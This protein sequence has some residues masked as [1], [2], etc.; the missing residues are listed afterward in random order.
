MST[1]FLTSFSEQEFRE[2]LRSTIKE[3]LSQELSKLS[4]SLPDTLG[5]EDAAAFLK[6]KIATIYEKTSK[7]LIPHF[8]KG[9]KLYFY[10]AELEQWI[11]SGNV[12]T[13][14]EIEGQAATWLL[15]GDNNNSRT[16]NKK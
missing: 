3:V 16:N 8:K 5:I 9:N 11:R 1:S 4:P 15:K 14:P 7:K 2:F 10:R 13:Q 6:L 12:R